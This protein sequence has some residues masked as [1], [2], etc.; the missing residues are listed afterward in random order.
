MFG[1]ADRS[2]WTTDLDIDSL[3]SKRSWAL[4]AELQAVIPYHSQRYKTVLQDCKKKSAVTATD[5][6]FATRFV[7]VFMFVKLKGCRP[8]TYLNLTVQKFEN[9][10][11]NGGMV[12]QTTFKTAQKYGFNYLYFDEISLDIIDD[13]VQYVRPLLNSHVMR[14][15]AIKSK[16][17]AV[18]ET[19]RSAKRPRV[20]SDWQVHTSDK[21]QADHRDRK[22]KQ[23]G[24]RRAT[25]RVWRPE[26]Q[27]ER[28]E[29]SLSKAAISRRC[30]KRT[31][32]H[33]KAA[34]RQGEKLWT[35]A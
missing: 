5:L 9:A 11:T 33:G 24:L 23:V 18:S 13:Y 28:G 14:L 15:L 6:T 22:R 4:L 32:V 27:L 35:F 12:D 16:R 2:H 29:S 1:E 3:E 8:M 7:A 34:G 10:K 26:A 20:S 19:H 21:V 25:S 31:N 17:F 30:F